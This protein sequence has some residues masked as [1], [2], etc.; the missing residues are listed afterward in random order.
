MTGANEYLGNA[1]CHTFVRAGW[2]TY[3]LVRRP[4]AMQELA[5]AE[6]IPIHGSAS[7]LSFI[8]VL[9]S[10]TAALD[11]IVSATEQIPEYVPH[12]DDTVR[13]LRALGKRSGDAGVKPLVLFSSGCKD[14]GMTALADEKELKNEE[15]PLALGS[16]PNQPSEFVQTRAKYAMKV[17][18]HNDAFDAVV[19]RPITLYGLSGS[20]YGPLFDAA[21]TAAR[22]RTAL[23]LPGH[24]RSILHG[25]HLE[26]CAEAYVAV[27]AK[28]EIAKGQCYNVSGRRYET[29]EVVATALVREYGI[30]GGIRYESSSAENEERSTMPLDFFA[31]LCGFGQWV[32]SEKVRR[33]TGWQDRRRLFSKGLKA[34]RLA[35]EAAAEEGHCGVGG[36]E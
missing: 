7:D 23:V 2:I 19:L 15:T 22:E 13:M 1:I 25:T 4:S 14:Y 21:A 34:Y 20:Y 29:L 11:V 17:F 35:H 26:D 6:I 9:F 18:E 36:V 30:E 10:Q 31:L 33:E 27:A 5:A 12:Y 16:G 3:G 24:P 28:A 8:D 32:G